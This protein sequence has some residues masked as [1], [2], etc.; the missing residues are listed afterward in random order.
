MEVEFT[1]TGP[2]AIVATDNGSN[3][4]HAPFPNSHRSLYA[5]RAVAWL[6]AASD[7]GE[8]VLRVATPGL[9]SD[10]VR[11]HAAPAAIEAELRSF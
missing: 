3:S 8:I 7:H 2:A 10:E 6:R 5:G 9:E 4:E 1:V 11:L